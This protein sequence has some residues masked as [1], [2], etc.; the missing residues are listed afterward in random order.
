MSYV[1]FETIMFEQPPPPVEEI[2][3]PPRRRFRSLI[4]S[5]RK[6][7]AR[8]PTGRRP[9][10]PRKQ[11]IV[12]EEADATLNSG[13]E[14]DVEALSDYDDGEQDDECTKS[15]KE[16]KQNGVHTTNGHKSEQEE[17]I[18]LPATNT[19]ISHSHSTPLKK[20][21]MA[22]AC[23]IT[24]QITSFTRSL[25]LTSSKEVVSPP[26]PSTSSKYE[27][28]AKSSRSGS[29][30]PSINATNKVDHRVA[31]FLSKKSCME[32]F[33]DGDEPVETLKQHHENGG[34][35]I[36]EVANVSV[37]QIDSKNASVNESRH[38]INSLVDNLEK[39]FSMTKDDTK[40]KLEMIQV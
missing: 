30:S 21:F 3:S 1:S 5:P 22:A 26:L 23:A 19:K 15:P 16:T 20:A 35:A 13:S 28:S 33:D 14:L 40:N 37:L 8:I 12:T 9:G 6:T 38:V 7:P 4:K 11:P 17:E 18:T 39:M 32:V 36:Y 24:D 2:A 10:R 34:S 25:K 29:P 31:Q 27:S